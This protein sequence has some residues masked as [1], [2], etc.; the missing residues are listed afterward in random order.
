MKTTWDYPMHWTS[1]VG[2]YNCVLFIVKEQCN[3]HK[4]TCFTGVPHRILSR[5]IPEDDFIT[6]LVLLN[7]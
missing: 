2:I 6:I 3:K 7:V 4:C 1:W 5:T